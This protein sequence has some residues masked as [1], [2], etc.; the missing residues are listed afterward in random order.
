MTDT[1]STRSLTRFALRSA[2]LGALVLGVLVGGGL[3][4]SSSADAD[5]V[6]LR[7]GE[8]IKCIPLAEESDDDRLVLEDLLTG[9][10]RTLRWDALVPADRKRLRLAMS[11]DS[12]GQATITGT[13]VTYRLQGGGE[14]SVTGVVTGR[15][16]REV[17]LKSNGTDFKIAVARIIEERAVQVDPREV[18][19]AEELYAQYMR[20]Q[21][22]AFEAMTGR[23]HMQ[24][25][26]KA[27]WVGA[28]DQ[29]EAHY[30]AAAEDTEFP[31]AGVA[32]K[33]LEEILEL[34]RNAE[35]LEEIKQMKRWTNMSRFERV[36][37]GLEAFG[38]KHGEL[39]TAVQARLD[40]L[41]SDFEAKRNAKLRDVARRA[42]PDACMDAIEAKVRE[43]DVTLT[44][45]SGWTRKEM[46]DIAWAEVV[47][48]MA[49]YDTVTPEEAQAFW[50]G[51][52][53]RVWRKISYGSGTFI[54]KPA[55]VKPPARRANNN[56]R[57]GGNAGV[58]PTTP[59]PPTRD[60]WWASAKS[61]ERAQWIMAYFVERSGLF[62]VNEVPLLRPC[63][64]CNGR[65]LQT[66][67]AS[68][69]ATHA[70]IC[71]R[72]AGSQSD[73]TVRYR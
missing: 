39:A 20:E 27:K 4:G 15:D 36:R 38:E 57:R 29:A 10:R 73:V 22:V 34:K 25:G 64:L 52:K 56:N 9:A 46:V 37:L 51:R 5:V 11:F 2:L 24:A 62:E 59:K 54:V 72:C 30:R 6:H 58:V 17:V 26:D 18:Y 14:D 32:A 13:V 66:K 49:Q 19:T 65:G 40:R 53:K 63:P 61:K 31:L 3:F 47:K 70:Y 21:G 1:T 43:K 23:Q 28:L 41:K 68:N 7:T 69:G 44:D 42:F 60:G 12:E 71:T 8:A 33:R 55:K 45:A 35:A 67:L 48:R 50:E 16:D